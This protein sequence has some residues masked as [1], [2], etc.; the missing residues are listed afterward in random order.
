MDNLFLINTTQCGC[1]ISFE[2]YVYKTH[3]PNEEKNQA[4]ATVVNTK[5]ELCKEHQEKI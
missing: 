2:L 3:V 1:I 4:K 5:V